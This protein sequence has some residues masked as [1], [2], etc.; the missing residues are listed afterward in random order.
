MTKQEIYLRDGTLFAHNFNRVV[1]GGRGP[2]VEFSEDQILLELES[3]FG[4]DMNNIDSLPFY[5]AWLVPIG[6]PTTKVYYQLKTVGYADYK[7][8][9]YYVSPDMFKD[10]KDPLILF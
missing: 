2:Y 10:F 7:I 5:Y 8:G 4:N 6:K 1:H 3:K 9:M